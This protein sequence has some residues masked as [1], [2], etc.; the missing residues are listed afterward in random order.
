MYFYRL[1]PPI[2]NEFAPT[3][4][5]PPIML[6][7]I[8]LRR[9]RPTAECERGRHCR[10]RIIGVQLRQL[11]PRDQQLPAILKVMGRCCVS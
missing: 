6:R 3:D 10:P 11:I 4:T 2:A 5:G 7:Y 8:L 1:N 9:L